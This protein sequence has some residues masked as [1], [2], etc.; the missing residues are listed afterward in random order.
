[1]ERTK[2]LIYGDVAVPTG[3]GR[4]GAQVGKYLLA[5]GYDVRGACV[6]YDGL[7]PPPTGVPF[8][9]SALQGKDAGQGPWGF[10]PVVGNI[11]RAWGADV[12]LSL[13]DFPYNQ[14]LRG[15]S[16]IDWSVTAHIVIT[17]IDGVPVFHQ[18]R[19]VAPQ[20]DALMT[21]SEFGVEALKDAGVRATLCPPGVDTSEFHRLP[22]AQRAELRDKVGLP[23]DAFVVGMMAMNQGR[24]D[25]PALVEGFHR[26]F[27]DI[28]NAYLYLDCDKVSP[29]GWDIP[30]SLVGPVGLNPERVKYREDAGRAGVLTLNER[31]NLLDLH[32]VIAHREGYGLPHTEAAATGCPTMAIDY[33]SGREVVGEHNERGALIAATPG[34]F[35]TWGGARDYLADIDDLARQMR[36]LHDHPA[37]LRARGAR[38]LEWAR[39]RTWDKT[40][41]VV[42][43]VLADVLH[44]RAPDLERRRQNAQPKPPAA[45]GIIPAGIPMITVNQPVYV[46]PAMPGQGVGDAA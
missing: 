34:R 7:L 10:S 11:A 25:F 45:P 24:K 32:G 16:G 36:W 43:T 29:A 17:P 42:A 30:H 27:K 9:V 1:M 4:I 40:G 20:F 2:V 13:Q 18:W 28:P 14:A 23:R 41:E 46:V 6:Q 44:K 38:A 3:F 22:D 39:A 19:D 31:Y 37:E 5:R 15:N 26:A 12:V 33:C 35:G 8:W 21:I